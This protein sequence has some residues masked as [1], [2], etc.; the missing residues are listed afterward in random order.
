MR[1]VLFTDNLADLTVEQACSAAMAAGFDGLDLT[2][3]PGGHVLPEN[4]EVGLSRAKRYADASGIAIPMVSTAVR[5]IDCPHTEAV[6]AAAAHYGARLVKLGYWEYRPFGTL[7]SQVNEARAKLTRL[8]AL[9]RKYHILPCVHCHSG[10]FIASGGPMLYLVLK[11]F[12]PGEVGAYVDPMH[13]TIEGGRA[14]W[15]M[16]LDLVAPW[17][18]L[19]GVKNFRWLPAERDPHGQQRW[20]WEYCPLADG[21]APLPEFFAYLQRLKYDGTISF[22]SEYKGET[23]FRRLT[24]TELLDQSAADLRYLKGLID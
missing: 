15:E 6:F 13:M 4:V 21:M 11:G 22:H 8:I 20:R 24:T 19:V 23:S 12:Q 14:G 7:A 16:G 18:A 3:R 9:G 10:R 2:L 1:F 5:D 17:I